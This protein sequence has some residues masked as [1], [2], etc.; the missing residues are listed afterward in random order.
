MLKNVFA[1]MDP[2][3][4]SAVRWFPSISDSSIFVS[5]FEGPTGSFSPSGVDDVGANRR[6][7][8]QIITEN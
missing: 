8:R 6:R 7:R 2:D 4:M 5:S 3:L 1:C